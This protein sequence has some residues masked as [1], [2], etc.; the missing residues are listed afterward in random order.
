VEDIM[1]AGIDYG[2]GRTNIDHA[3]GIRYGV[4]S[5]HDVMQ[6]WCDSSTADYGE[7]ACPKC[8]QEV[9]SADADAREAEQPNLLVDTDVAEYEQYNRG[10]SDYVCHTCKHTL[11]NEDVYG[12]EPIGYTLEEDGYIAEDCLDSDI[13]LLKSDYYTYAPF[14]SPCAPGAGDLN[15]AFDA[16]E[17]PDTGFIG[18]VEWMRHN[19]STVKTYCFGHDWFEDGKAPY[20]VFRVSDD[21][22]VFPEK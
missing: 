20:R 6:A 9:I 21:S 2:M 1:S 3:T 17:K 15:N 11:D 13:M 4:I 14:C 18:D 16:D 12:E 19:Q 7:P 5:M 22:E 10:C 8:G